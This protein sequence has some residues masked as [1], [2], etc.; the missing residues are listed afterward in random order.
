MFSKLVGG[1]L[2]NITMICSGLICSLLFFW[3]HWEVRRF[4]SKI[5]VIKGKSCL[6]Q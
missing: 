4:F 5:R 2:Q 6:E 1:N 3:H